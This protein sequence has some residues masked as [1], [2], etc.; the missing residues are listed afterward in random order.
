MQLSIP[1][2][3][4]LGLLLASLYGTI[5]HIWRGRSLSDLPRFLLAGWLGFAL[6]H[7]GGHLLHITPFRI[8]ELNVLSASLGAWVALFIAHRL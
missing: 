1:P 8:G 3:W 6:G 7:L 5:F 4:A 2:A